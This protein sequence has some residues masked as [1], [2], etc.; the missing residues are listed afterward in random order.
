MNTTEQVEISQIT[1]QEMA[2]LASAKALLECKSLATRLTEVAGQPLEEGLR[3][4]PQGWQEK[5]RDVTR[6][7]LLK[8]MDL[9]VITINPQGA[10]QSSELFHKGLVSASGVIG[11][12]FGLPALLVE[13]PVSTTLMLRSI[14]DIARSEGH[15]LA[16]AEVKL[17]CLEV[18]ALGGV[19]ENEPPAAPPPASEAPASESSSPPESAPAPPPPPPVTLPD[20]SGGNYWTVRDALK[21]PFLE[22]ATYM[23]VRGA[24][25]ATAAPI[26]G[27]I[28]AVGTRFSALV[29]H[30]IAAKTIPAISAATGSLVNLLFMDHFQNMAR[31]H[32]IVKRLEAKYGSAEIRRLYGGITIP[33]S[34][35]AGKKGC[36]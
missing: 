21:P 32:F 15:D 29:I 18:L 9:A 12:L 33:T 36:C 16:Q 1:A 30:Q 17:S 28:T 6:S 20:T 3:R 34:R 19:K 10:R 14:A 2:D 25:Q 26:L 24:I 5:V 11:G 4:L 8:G 7:A 23:G 31:G 35:L 22:A 13:L 27:F